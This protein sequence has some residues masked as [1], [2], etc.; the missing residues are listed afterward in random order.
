MAKREMPDVNELRKKYPSNSKTVKKSENTDI[1]NDVEQKQINTVG[2][3]KVRKKSP[4]KKLVHSIIEDNINEAKDRAY[5]DVI[6]P[7]LKSL[8]FDTS[9]DILESMIY[10][11]DD[12]G[13]RDRRRRFNGSFREERTS[14]GSFYKDGSRNDDRGSERGNREYH[15]DE[16]ILDTRTQAIRALDELDRLIHKYGQA[17]VAELYDIVELSGDW[18]D[19]RYGWTSSRGFSVRHINAG[20][21]IVTP[22]AE[23]LD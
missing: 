6:V 20:Y 3:A 4:L 11:K 12:E 18:T 9:I 14:Y 22:P 16:I 8:L 10:G 1:S 17:S 13:R 7:G 21:L 2:K 5:N 15:P 19:H 23:L